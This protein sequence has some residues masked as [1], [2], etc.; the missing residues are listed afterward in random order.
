MKVSIVS[1]KK[2]LPTSLVY[3]IRPLKRFVFSKIFGYNFQADGLSTTGHNTDFL[4]TP[5]FKSAW[6]AAER[7]N[8]AGWNDKV[9]DIRW[10]A[11]IACW[12]A[13]HAVKL[14]GDFVECG[15]HTGILSHAV[16]DYVDFAQHNASFWLFDTFEGIPEQQLAASEQA[17]AEYFNENYYFDC[18]DIVQKSFA[19]YPNVHLVKGLIPASLEQAEINAVSYLSIDLNNAYAEVAALEYFWDKMSP[20]GMIILDDYGFSAHLEQKTAIDAFL[21]SKGYNAVTLPTGQ[22]LVI[23]HPES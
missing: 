1:L 15:V 16:C 5:R 4:D 12:A 6:E 23:I 7:A 2:Y 18:F 3:K 20:S 9:P 8:Q 21:A 10:R 13:E 11:H 14:K 22:G 17:N 19:K